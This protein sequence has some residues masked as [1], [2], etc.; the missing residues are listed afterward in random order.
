MTESSRWDARDGQ[1][2]VDGEQQVRLAWA[3]SCRKRVPSS[4]A[5]MIFLSRAYHPFCSIRAMDVLTWSG[6][7]MQAI[8]GYLK[9]SRRRRP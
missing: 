1:L 2:L 6:I 8:P 5:I 7:S 3:E 4:F 9:R